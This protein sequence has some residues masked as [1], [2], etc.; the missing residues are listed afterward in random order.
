MNLIRIPNFENKFSMKDTL[1]IYLNNN[2]VLEL[3]PDAQ[4]GKFIYQCIPEFA[5]DLFKLHLDE[6]LNFIKILEI[7]LEGCS[8][9]IE[10]IPKKKLLPSEKDD[11]I[12]LWIYLW[13]AIFSSYEDREQPYR[14]LQLIEVF[15]NYDDPN[16]RNHINICSKVMETCLLYG[17]AKLAL[18][19]FETINISLIS[20][21]SSVFN[22]Y[23][24][25]IKSNEL[26][27][28]FGPLHLIGD[29]NGTD[30]TSVV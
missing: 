10:S 18:N 24:F 9:N 7:E 1:E 27:R 30:R 25:A 11:A 22:W 17:S 5:P 19:F 6:P 16:I 21:D 13:C 14:L 4:D 12:E 8:F 23:L 29:N 3:M 15:K 20:S 26:D 2:T 28:N